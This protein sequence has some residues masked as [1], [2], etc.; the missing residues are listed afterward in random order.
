MIATNSYNEMFINRVNTVKKGYGMGR[1]DYFVKSDTFAN[2]LEQKQNDFPYAGLANNGVIEY[3]GVVFV[4][5]SKTNSI[6]LGDVSDPRKTLN[7]SLPSG[8]NLKVNVD[9]LEDLSKAAGMF[10]PEDLNA[11]LRAIEQYKHCSSKLKEIDDMENEIGDTSEETSIKRSFQVA[12][13]SYK[14]ENKLTPEKIEKEDDWRHMEDT[15]WNKLLNYV[16]KY[17]DAVKEEMEKLEEKQNEAAIESANNAPADMKS[18]AASSAALSVAANG[19]APAGSNQDSFLEKSSWTYELETD[20]QAI[21]AKAKK[22]NKFV[23][24]M[25]S[26]AQEI[27]LVGE[28]AVGISEG[29]NAKEVATVEEEDDEKTRTIISV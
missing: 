28:T 2:I 6:S 20:D 22:A 7:I 8:G 19:I 11:I 18:I 25:R 17:I 24:D 16:D 9:N 21:L 27:A 15:Q 13:D 10:T 26:K 29:Q 5:D 12:V 14:E 3:N 1:I 4:G 23:E